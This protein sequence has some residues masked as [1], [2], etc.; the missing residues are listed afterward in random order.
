MVIA[1]NDAG[2][3][4]TTTSA[5]S[6]PVTAASDP[7]DLSAVPGT[8]LGET[9]CQ[10]LVGGAKYR[11][12]ALAGIGTVRVRAYT[13]G[14]ALRSSPLR[15]TTEITGGRAKSVRYRFDGRAVAAARGARHPAT[16]TPASSA[17][18][19]CTR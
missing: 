19:A 11:R 12:V 17:R 9:S 1:T 14:P 8:L 13:S 4:T 5:P 10:Q 15:L 16:L 18:S 3:T 2:S 6:A 7:N